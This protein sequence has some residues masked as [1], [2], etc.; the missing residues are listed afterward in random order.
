MDGGLL[1]NGRTIAQWIVGLLYKEW[2]EY[3]TMDGGSICST[4]D[5]GIT[6]Q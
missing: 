6:V 5:G 3:S 1:P 2:W 4:M